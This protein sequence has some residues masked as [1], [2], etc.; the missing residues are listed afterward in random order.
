MIRAFFLFL[1]GVFLC[2]LMCPAH[3]DTRRCPAIERD[4]AGRIV[5]SATVLRQFQ[6]IHP[7]P[8]TGGT[9][10][11]C[12]GWSIDH[13][14]P[15]ACGGCDQIENLQWLKNSIKTCAGRE[16]KDRWERTVYCRPMILVK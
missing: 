5:R 2:M 12:K 11:P 1:L 15:L 9:V 6:E 14:I 4:D 7:C 3:A 16:C 10:G 8:V 13:V